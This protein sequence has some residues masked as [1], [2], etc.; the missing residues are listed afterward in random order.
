VDAPIIGVVIPYYQRMGGLLRR[1]VESVL[2]QTGLAGVR[3]TILVVDDASPL[4]PG[5]DLTGLA[6]SEN[7]TIEI[8]PRINGGPGA[9]RNTGIEAALAGGCTHLAFLDSDDWWE[10]P[11][12]SVALAGLTHAPFFFG[13]SMHDEVPSFSYFD[14]MRGRAI[15][16]VIHGKEAFTTMLAEC[17][18]HTSQVVYSLRDFPDVRFDE[19]M[20]RT[21]EDHLFWLTIAD[22]GGA[23]AYSTKIL[24]Q[25]GRGVS[26]YREALAWDSSAFIPRLIDAFHLR[27]LIAQRFVLS[28]DVAQINAQE[29]RKAAEEIAFAIVRRLRRP[30]DLPAALTAVTREGPGLWSAILA[31]LPSLPRIR[32]RMAAT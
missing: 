15:E 22:R 24:G 10:P 3:V 30:H 17:V 23:M 4:P 18:P 28:P 20:K 11:H 13:N 29:R 27:T 21:G 5:I 16:G 1:A 2:G 7:M 6:S 31:A 9:A 14:G 8:V 19:T 12:L 32:R 26:V 25:R